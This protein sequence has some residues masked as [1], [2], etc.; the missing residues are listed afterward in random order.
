MRADYYPIKEERAILFLWVPRFV[1]GGGS[2]SSRCEWLAG[3]G[4]EAV[5]DGEV[6]WSEGRGVFVE[7]V[8]WDG[9]MSWW[10]GLVE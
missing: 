3:S 4:E 6:A 5:G 7:W 9:L 1:E 8:E 2:V 10:V